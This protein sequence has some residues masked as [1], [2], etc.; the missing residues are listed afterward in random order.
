MA[1]WW[2]QRVSVF[3]VHNSSKLLKLWNSPWF[4]MIF[5]CRLPLQAHLSFQRGSSQLAAPPASREQP[6]MPS[7]CAFNQYL[8]DIHGIWLAE[9]HLDGF[10][11]DIFLKM[12]KLTSINWRQNMCFKDIRLAMGT[13]IRHRDI[14]PQMGTGRSPC[15]L[16]F[17]CNT[18]HFNVRVLKARRNCIDSVSNLDVSVLI[19][20]SVACKIDAEN[21]QALAM[22]VRES[23]SIVRKSEVTTNL[24]LRSSAIS[25]R[26]NSRR[27]A[28][29]TNRS[30][31]ECILLFLVKRW[32]KRYKLYKLVPAVGQYPFFLL[33]HNISILYYMVHYIILYYI[34]LYYIIL[35]HIILYIII[36]YHSLLYY[37]ISY[38]IISYYI[39]LYYIILYYI[40]YYISYFIIC[41]Y[42]LLYVIICY[43]MLLYVII[44]YYMLYYVILYVILDIICSYICYCIT[45]YLILYVI[46]LYFV[47][48]VVCNMFIMLFLFYIIVY[49]IF[50]IIV[51]CFFL[52]CLRKRQT[53]DQWNHRCPGCKANPRFMAFPFGH[54]PPKKMEQR[55]PAPPWMV[56]TP[57]K[58]GPL[59]SSVGL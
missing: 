58:W 50:Y 12:R 4:S 14:K 47:S 32:I 22:R 25:L 39:M 20:D 21:G 48:F 40:S 56:E 17:P 27:W 1:I 19:I 45:L 46:L 36:L 28:P 29:K 6:S 53:F 31:P 49:N 52:C 38:Y 43:Y 10:V 8:L 42:M 34:T 15:L 16:D 44:W 51:L 3:L 23:S 59:D 13:T 55:N 11:S 54:D 5:N 24:S 57:T 7:S 18:S 30:N 26:F 35:K 2:H 9:N 33:V 37:I 41:Y